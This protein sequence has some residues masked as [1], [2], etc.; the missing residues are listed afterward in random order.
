[1]IVAVIIDSRNEYLLNITYTTMNIIITNKFSTKI[2]IKKSVKTE[3][4][5]F[6]F[7]ISSL[8]L[9]LNSSC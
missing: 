1:M 8:L 7:Q 3:K 2:L 9:Q 4:L 6:D 5:P